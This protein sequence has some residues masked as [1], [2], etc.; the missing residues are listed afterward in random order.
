MIVLI[1]ID[2]LHLIHTATQDRLAFENT[3]GISGIVRFAPKET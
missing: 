3:A 1:Q 2:F